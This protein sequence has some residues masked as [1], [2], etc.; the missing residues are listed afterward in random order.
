VTEKI[1]SPIENV[2]DSIQ[3]I[4]EELQGKELEDPFLLKRILTCG[5]H[6]INLCF[7]VRLQPEQET[8]DA[9]VQDYFHS[10]DREIE[11]GRDAR[12]EDREH[13]GLLQVLDLLSEGDLDSLKPD[14]YHGWTD[15]LTR[16]KELR[17]KV[18]AT[19]Q[20]SISAME[21]EDLLYLLAV[22]HR[23]SFT[24]TDTVINVVVAA[25][26]LE[27]LFR[28]LEALVDSTWEE[29]ARMKE[30]LLKCCQAVA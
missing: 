7:Y 15:K 30:I 17:S 8:F 10:W 6:A 13:L 29:S 4:E 27:I 23:L 11:V 5:W 16:C 22:H 19:T 14:F 2:L 25:K 21:R 28:T 9:W 3:C 1:I 20:F 12:L 24:P 26:K 18:Q